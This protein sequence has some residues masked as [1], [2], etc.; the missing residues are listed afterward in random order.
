MTSLSIT[1][2]PAFDRFV[3]ADLCGRLP[4]EDEIEVGVYAN[5]VVEHLEPPEAAFREWR[6]L[7]GPLEPDT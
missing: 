5:F 7:F 6:R 4:F 3:V 2:A 1:P